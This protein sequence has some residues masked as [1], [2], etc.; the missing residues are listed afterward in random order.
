MNWYLGQ[1]FKLQAN[2]IRAFSD[3]GALAL[4]P[5]IMELRAQISL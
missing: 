2:Y 3:K 4:D 5:K 1:H